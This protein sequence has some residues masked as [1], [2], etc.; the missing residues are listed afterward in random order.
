MDLIELNVDSNVN[1]YDF[2]KKEV[3]QGRNEILLSGQP[4]NLKEFTDKA[5]KTL[6]HFKIPANLRSQTG[7]ILLR[8][9]IMYSL[10]LEGTQ[11]QIDSDD[12]VL[13]HIADLYEYFMKLWD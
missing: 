3:S 8:F 4:F 7:N 9:S 1:I 12:K 5:D 2:L 11:L 13:N 10:Q 6:D